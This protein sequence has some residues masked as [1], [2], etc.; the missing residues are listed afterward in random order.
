MT[1]RWERIASG[2]LRRAIHILMVLIVVV[3]GGLHL[4]LLQV[5]AWGGMLA[6]NVGDYEV[7]EAL[8]RTFDG[9]HPCGLCELVD[10]AADA[11]DTEPYE[12][13]RPVKTLRLLF[14]RAEGVV[15]VA[16]TAER[17]GIE[18]SEARA[19]ARPH[20]P[21]VPPPRGLTVVG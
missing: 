5:V 4:G 21:E 8:T 6:T 18:I 11:N 7:G 1:C 12:Q 14:V 19:P 15:V 9:E 2:V 20:L 10:A 3:S 17:A 13:G 16:P